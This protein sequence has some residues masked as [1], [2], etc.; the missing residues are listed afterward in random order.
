M[1]LMWFDHLVQLINLHFVCSRTSVAHRFIL[2][3]RS[4]ILVGRLNRTSVGGEET[5]ARSPRRIRQRMSIKRD[6]QKYG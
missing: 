1:S 4:K 2:Q 5:A 3:G 6:R